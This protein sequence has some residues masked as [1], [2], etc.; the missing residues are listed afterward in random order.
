[1][2]DSASLS[3]SLSSGLTKSAEKTRRVESLQLFPSLSAFKNAKADDL[4][5]KEFKKHSKLINLEFNFQK[6]RF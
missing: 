2:S 6:P 4:D 5:L 3:K 1:M